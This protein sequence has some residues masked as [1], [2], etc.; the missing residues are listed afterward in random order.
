[1]SHTWMAGSLPTCTHRTGSK[2]TS[3]H[4]QFTDPMRHLCVCVCVCVRVCVHLSRGSI[5]LQR[6]DAEAQDV[7]VMAEV[8]ALTVQLSVVDHA[9]RRHVVQHLPA[10]SVEEVVPAVVPTVPAHTHTHTH[11]FINSFTRRLNA[12]TSHKSTH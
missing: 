11:T 3:G 4:S 12:V 1:M 10:L 9:H 7:V 2:H 8:E 6:V 5:V